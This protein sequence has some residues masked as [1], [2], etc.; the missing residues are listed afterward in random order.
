VPAHDGEP[1]TIKHVVYVLKENRTYDQIFGDMPQGNADPKLCIYGEKITPNHHALAR[2]FVLL[3]N[4]YCNGVVSADGHQWA[5]QGIVTDY[6]EKDFGGFTRSYDFGTDALCYAS[7]N[8]LW[9][10]AL[11]NGLTFR[12]YGEFDFPELV[13]PHQT[14][15][16]VYHGF[17]AGKTPLKQSVQID[18][19]RKY[20]CPDY[21]R[22]GRAQR[23]AD[24][25]R[26]LWRRGP[27]H[28]A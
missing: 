25:R 12:N 21:L 14:W 2:Q 27:G 28:R 8:F 1:S 15:F 6:Q 13:D 20:T 7:S 9:D 19:L 3:D 4:Y 17:D 23:D 5:M 22:G 18:L 10:S 16:D 11:L 26:N 24:C